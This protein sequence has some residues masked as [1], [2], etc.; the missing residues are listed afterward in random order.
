M[1]QFELKLF[2]RIC[3]SALCLVAIIGCQN[4]GP[5]SGL[6][7]I[8]QLGASEQEYLPKILR[9]LPDSEVI[10]YS[11][12]MAA[13][14]KKQTQVNSQKVV[15][16]GKERQVEFLFNDSILGHIWISFSEKEFDLVKL[17]LTKSFGQIAI[18]HD[19][20]IVFESKNV[21]LSTNPCEILLADSV[22][23]FEIIG[24]D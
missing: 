14:F 22:L 9:K 18:T 16:L 20:Y 6:N 10:E 2:Y 8:F 24:I 1:S 19:P 3:V 12:S 23:L 21:A 13:P 11:D 7:P 5:Y 15:V 17:H 4:R